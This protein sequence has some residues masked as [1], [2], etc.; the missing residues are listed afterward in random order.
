MAL[1]CSERIDA[2]KQVEEMRIQLMANAYLMAPESNPVFVDNETMRNDIINTQS[3]RKNFE[4]S[5]S[6][7]RLSKQESGGELN[8][9]IACLG[10]FIYAAYL[11]AK[12]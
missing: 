12:S 5:E 7:E 1:E 8:G 4:S 2:Q 3:K 11:L 10:V 6:R 9:I